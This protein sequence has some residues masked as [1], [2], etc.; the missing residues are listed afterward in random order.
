LDGSDFAPGYF[1]EF[2]R[3]RDFQKPNWYLPM[4]GSGRNDRWRVEQYMSFMN[5]LQGMAKPPDVLSHRPSQSD[6]TDAVV[7]TNQVMQRLGT[8]FTTM[9]VTRPRV[10]V[11]WP[12]SDA[13]HDEMRNIKQ[14][15]AERR[16]HGRFDQLLY[17]YMGSKLIQTPI[18][19][20]VEE[21]IADGTL[22]AHHDVLML[23]GID[24]LNADILSAIDA[25][26]AGGGKVLLS[27]D[28]AIKIKNA[29][30]FHLPMEGPALNAHMSEWGAGGQWD[31]WNGT[32]VSNGYY[33]AALPAAKALKA[34]FELL[35]IKPVFESD[36]PGIV[37][38]REA[39]GDVEYIFAL[40][41]TATFDLKEWDALKGVTA[42]IKL[43]GADRPVYDAMNSGSAVELKDQGDAMAGSLRFGPGQL[44]VFARTARPIG[45]V[46]LFKPTIVNDYSLPDP[47]HVAVIAY[48]MDN[49]NR[50]LTG[51]FPLRVRLFDPLGQLRYDLYRATEAGILRLSLPLAVNDPAGEYRLAVSELLNETTS[52]TKFQYTPPTQ[53]GALAGATRRAVSFPGEMENVARFFRLHKDVTIATGSSAYNQVQADRLV[54][55]LQPWN[56]TAKIITAAEANKPRPISE[57]EAH[58]WAGL[59]GGARAGAKNNPASVGFD[60]RGPVIL[61]GTPLD[62]PIIKFLVDQKFLPYVPG[63]QF[64]GAGRGYISWQNDGVGYFNQ[65]SITLIAYDGAG[66]SEAVGT[67]Y[68][69][70]AGQTPLTTFSL[71]SGAQITR[72]QHAQPSIPAPHE[73]WRVKL[74]DRPVAIKPLPDGGCVALDVSGKLSI[75][76]ST[77][78]IAWSKQIDGGEAWSLSVSDDGNVICVGASQHV[79]AF[80]GAG[81]QLFDVAVQPGEQGVVPRV[82]FVAVSP[83]GKRIAFADGLNYWFGK[84]WHWGGRL[85]MLDPAG[86]T[87]WTIGGP[88]AKAD[89]QSPIADCREATF[90]GDGK[91]L[92]MQLFGVGKKPPTACII[93]AAAT[94]KL[95][96]DIAD[97][98]PR[99]ASVRSGADWLVSDGKGKLSRIS[100]GGKISALLSAPAST[101][102]VAFAPWKD[103]LVIGTESDST[104]CLLPA[105]ASELGEHAI[106]QHSQ[107][108]LI[109]KHV[110]AHG[111]L[112][113]ITWWGGL[114]EIV[115]ENGNVKQSRRFDRDVTACTW[116]GEHL[117]V[118]LATGEVVG[119]LYG[120]AR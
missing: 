33:K 106:W 116:S 88:D 91:T 46:E 4:W 119:I 77:G 104:V 107:P 58:T 65:E 112:L 40:N 82:E 47:I 94:G 61:L 38:S 52:E 115:D 95:I 54:Q 44:R 22:A 80:D 8:I 93:D 48:V 109:V 10:A 117:I 23:V 78:E 25:F 17:V 26:T 75:I 89:V 3:M 101:G 114:L 37:A 51:S 42:A 118:A 73:D 83:D 86:Q 96:G 67:L 92:M 16:G 57:E 34:A 87:M 18:W 68:Q 64:P 90:S 21:D 39:F 24:Y 30:A 45:G 6:V 66:M 120:V 100:P 7:E 85:T 31:K 59:Q 20:V 36:Q 63:P 71:P 32:M 60:V 103:R 110:A 84:G 50:P 35:G 13:L 19:P 56:I 79:V 99:V 97:V 55:I 11:L 105:T 41:A 69:A 81:K 62:N 28:S 49:K 2:G 98:S 15:G 113:A 111:D 14:I 70:M 12:L 43:P 108:K 72:A 5:N 76:K 74:N 1:F 27:D 53:C 29:V 102:I 9:P